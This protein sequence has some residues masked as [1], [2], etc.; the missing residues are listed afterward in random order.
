MLCI[1]QGKNFACPRNMRKIHISRILYCFTSIFMETMDG[2]AEPG[3]FWAVL[4]NE[5]DAVL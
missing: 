5:F 1:S 3:R 2:D 4:F